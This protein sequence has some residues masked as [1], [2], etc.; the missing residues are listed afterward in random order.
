[1]AVTVGVNSGAVSGTVAEDEKLAQDEEVLFYEES[2]EEGKVDGDKKAAGEDENIAEVGAEAEGEK[3][4]E[5][6][7]AANS[8]EVTMAVGGEKAADD[9]KAVAAGTDDAKSASNGA[10]LSGEGVADFSL[11]EAASGATELMV[12]GVGSGG[13]ASRAEGAGL[14]LPSG[15]MYLLS[16]ALAPNPRS[17]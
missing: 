6:G 17:R 8:V 2:R 7:E 16:N 12:S 14:S 9:D 11:L 5:G 10:S 4:A 13:R 3:A 1:M 15:W